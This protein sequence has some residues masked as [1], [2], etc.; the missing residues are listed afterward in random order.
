M[1]KGPQTPLVLLGTAV[2]SLLEAAEASGAP[3][4]RALER[5]LRRDD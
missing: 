4:P 5:G 3:V 2:L 1:R